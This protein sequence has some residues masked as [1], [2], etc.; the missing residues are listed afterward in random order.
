MTTITTNQQPKSI[1][2]PSP[3]W[4]NTSPE[5]EIERGFFFPARLKMHLEHLL[6]EEKNTT[7]S[8]SEHQKTRCIFINAFSSSL[9]W[10]E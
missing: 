4:T 5:T 8:N 2:N 1:A 7:P 3:T 10:L 9:G 6:L